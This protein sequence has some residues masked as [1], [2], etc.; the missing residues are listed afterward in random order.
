MQVPKREEKV[1]F[2]EGQS[3]HMP[4]NINKDFSVAHMMTNFCLTL[5]S[6]VVCVLNTFTLAVIKSFKLHGHSMVVV[7][8]NDP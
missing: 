1:S 4:R 2:P 7:G 3:T 6:H 8:G 5:A